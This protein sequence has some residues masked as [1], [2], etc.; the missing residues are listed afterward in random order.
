MRG[1]LERRCPGAAFGFYAPAAVIL[2]IGL[3]AVVGG[4]R[5]RAQPENQSRSPRASSLRRCSSPGCRDTAVRACTGPTCS[6]SRGSRSSR[7]GHACGCRRRRG[8]LRMA[9][10]RLA[11]ATGVAQ[12]L[13][14]VRLLRARSSPTTSRRPRCAPRSGTSATRRRA[15][16]ASSSRRALLPGSPL[17]TRRSLSPTARR[18]SSS[19]SSGAAGSGARDLP[20]SS[21]SCGG[22]RPPDLSRAHPPPERLRTPRTASCRRGR[23]RGLVR[24]LSAS[25]GLPA[26]LPPSGGLD[27]R[28]SGRPGSERSTCPCCSTTP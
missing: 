11:L 2:T 16:R 9:D 3:L 5:M 4:L 10:R 14:A 25:R 26:R 23:W 12:R 28:G 19:P 6:H 27:L 24:A 15:R 18:C 1:I 20:A 7:H 22:R 8:R 17:A 21:A 13:H